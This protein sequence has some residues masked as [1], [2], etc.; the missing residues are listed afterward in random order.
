M[1]KNILT[2]LLLS[3]VIGT[4]AAGNSFT[5]QKTK[6]DFEARARELSQRTN[7]KLIPSTATP[8]ER[9]ALEF[10][11]AYMQLPDATDYSPEFYLE[12]V[13]S[14]LKARNEMD[15]GKT[16]PDREWRHFV[17][18]VRINNENLDMS[19]PVFYE[20]LKERVKGLTMEEAILEVNHW[21]HEKVTYQPC[22]PRTSSPLATV[23]NA[24]GRCGE[25]STF[26][27]AA[28]RAVGIPSRQVYTPRWAH[29]DDNHAWVEAWANGKWYFLGACEPEAVLNLGWFN[30]PARRGMLMNTNVF[31]DYDGPEEVLK[32][33][34]T[35]TQINVTSNYAP[36][37]VAKVKVVDRQGNPVENATVNFS[38]YNY[39]EFFPISVK[40]SSKDG[41]AEMIC[42]NGDLVIW[43]SDG[44]NFGLAK[45]SP[46]SG[47]TEIVLD[48]DSSYTGSIT[49]DIVPPPAGG[50]TVDVPADKAEENLIRKVKEDSIR[51]AYTSTFFT[52]REAREFARRLGMDEEKSVTVLVGCRGNRKAISEFLE[53]AAP[54]K[55]ARALAMLLA[56]A[57]KDL[58]D[59][60]PE[61]L[62][63]H[64]E[65]TP[66]V[67]T[68]LYADYVLNPRVEWEG[69]TPYKKFFR[70][71]FSKRDAKRFIANPQE[72]VRWYAANVKTSDKWNNSRLRMHPQSVVT[73]G[74]SD[75]LSRDIS[76]V[77]AARSLGIPA[78]IDVVTSK[79][80]YADKTG[81]W[82]DVKFSKDT[83]RTTVATGSARFDYE[84]GNRRVEPKYE[85]QFTISKIENGLPYLMQYDDF[86]VLSNVA[87]KTTALDEGQYVLITGQR[88]ADGSVLSQVQFFRADP[89]AEANVPF[90][91]RQDTTGVQVIGSFNAENLYRT[92]DGKENSIISTTGRGY[93]V[94]GL[95]APGHEPS[96]HGL[97]DISAMKDEFEK[98]GKKIMILL[99]SESALERFDRS[100]FGNL[101]S[102]VEIGIDPDGA[103]AKEIIES[104]NLPGN[105]LPIFIIADTFN[106]IVFASQGYTIGLGEKLIDTIHKLKE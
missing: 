60:T 86:D 94:V 4:S 52:E 6:T 5:P 14:S 42:G 61:V 58:H 93:Y 36:T 71:F 105:D 65:N 50:W 10:L 27:V 56:V 12:N 2:A 106:R 51:N 33:N 15:W 95:I 30:A 78:R 23:S 67:S 68:P 16:V 69:L 91:L 98:W 75:A 11:Y 84:A 77:A 76:F 88:M 74:I 44:T 66:E 47:V 80:Q 64:F 35:T 102:T 20:E 55:R 32:R 87:K 37:R 29:T 31:G 9:E 46:D 72:L 54:G 21:C 19:R 62:A 28:L 22:D 104:L 100:L 49:L 18:P 81:K 34:E 99:P 48:K 40:K 13:R 83:P 45:S 38:L 41:E 92:P 82:I 103:N 26:T 17:L 73:T 85:S 25:E 70:D 96:A 53:N 90:V 43:A 1:N 59:I 89:K 97:N 63:D 24:L 7:Q 39:A 101:P 57:E 79:T 8:E 3:A